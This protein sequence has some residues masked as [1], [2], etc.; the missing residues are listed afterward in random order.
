MSGEHS[1]VDDD[2]GGD[3]D[4]GDDDDNGDNGG[5]GARSVARVAFIEGVANRQ[6]NTALDVERCGE[7]EHGQT[8]LLFSEAGARST[9]HFDT[10]PYSC[11]SFHLIGGGGPHLLRSP[12]RQLHPR[13]VKRGSMEV[14]RSY[15]FVVLSDTCELIEVGPAPKWGILRRCQLVGEIDDVLPLC[16]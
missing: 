16:T 9:T 5:G 11:I 13:N 14:V 2:N 1:F 10:G 7:I 4:D 8:S 6:L 15:A 3:S 12:H